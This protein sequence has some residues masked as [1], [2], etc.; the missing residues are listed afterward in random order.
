[1]LDI[2]FDTDSGDKPTM[3]IRIDA[4]TAWELSDFVLE[5]LNGDD[6]DPMT[7]APPHPWHCG[8]FTHGLKAQV[9]Q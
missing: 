5:Y 1:M 2:D 6:E 4:D 9:R 3:R 7:S 8:G